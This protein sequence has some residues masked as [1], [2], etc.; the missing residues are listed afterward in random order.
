ML[1]RLSALAPHPGRPRTGH[2]LVACGCFMGIALAAAVTWFAISSRQTVLNDAVRE[3][4]NDALLLAEQEDRQLQAVETV[5]LGLIEH[6]RTA[7]IDSPEEFE[8]SMAT[9]DVQQNLKDRI[10]GLSHVTAL[11]LAG[12]RGNLLNISYV[13]PVPPVVDAERDFIRRLAADGTAPTF[14]SAPVV[15][16]FTGQRTT[17]LSRRFDAADGTLIGFVICSI[18]IDQFEQL[19]SRLPLTGAGAF[20]LYRRD[21]VLI[22]RYPHPDPGTGQSLADTRNFNS[23]TAALNNGAIWMKGVLDGKDSLIVP[24]VLANFPLI[25]VV[26]DTIESILRSWLAEIRMLVAATV[27]LELAIAGTMLLAARHLRGRER[28]RE[29]ESARERAE[30]DLALATEREHTAQTLRQHEHRFDRAVNN[31]HQGL[32]MYDQASRIVVANRRFS[33]LFALPDDAVSPGVP[34]D[35]VTAMV[36]AAGVVTPADME[37]LRDRRSDLIA[38]RSRTT[39]NWDLASGRTLMITH[40]P[41]DSGWLTTYEDITERRAA[42]ARISYMA[43]HDALTNLPNR[44]LFR[45]NLGHALAF[46]R[47]GHPLALLCLGLDQFKAVNDTLGHPIGDDLLRAVADRLRD[48]LRETDTIARL[49]GDEFAIVQTAIESPTD[50]TELAS[51]LIEV[52][53]VPFEI[54]GHQ[55]VI[56]ASIGIAFAPEDGLDADQLLKCADL[57]LYR[58]KIDGRGVYRLFQAEMDAAMQVRRMLELELRQALSGGQLE[59]YYQPQI[60]V[61]ARQ[62]CGFEALLRWRHPKMGLVAPDR[63]IALAEETGMIVAIGEWVL[64]QA[65]AAAAHWPDPLKIAVNVSAVQFKSRDLVGAVVGALRASGLPASRLELEI[66]ES[67]MLQDTDA[68]LATLHQLRDLGVQI[69]MDDF[70]TGYSSLSYLRRFPFDRIKIDQSFIRELGKPDDSIAIVRAVVTLGRDLGMAITAE[71]VETR[72]QLDRLERVGCTEIQ[73][74]LFSRP[75][76]EATVADLLRSMPVLEDIW[77]PPGVSGPPGPVEA[78]D[79]RA[80]GRVP[81][82]VIPRLV[83]GIVGAS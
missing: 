9:R 78:G 5:Q 39:F 8:R 19:F 82:V 2:L 35:I 34:Y 61:R 36:V 42:E 27:L 31:M 29:A 79:H 55:I 47:R 16:R 25:V 3:M 38:S 6:M 64:R 50:A 11:A 40:Q 59:L 30:T 26:S 58:A 14:I 60:D 45:E 41:M 73:G 12:R 10:A 18:R 71:G 28:L 4:R 63:F 23:V 7:G 72:Q 65:C 22:A 74:Y 67:V 37:G 75:V 76:P 21:G 54:D 70:G 52:I 43:Y 66:T 80:A 81:V 48:S 83:R 51:R 20:S 56:G 53:E 15:S 13:W 44:V 17:F 24:R 62:V 68:T 32:C 1:P 33:E 57:A 69:A 77:P 49:G 46:S